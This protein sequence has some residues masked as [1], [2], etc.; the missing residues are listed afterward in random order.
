IG[1]VSPLKYQT[2]HHTHSSPGSTAR[3]LRPVAEPF[4]GGTACAFMRWIRGPSSRNRAGRRSCHSVGGST[5]WS[6]T[7][8]IRS[9][10]VVDMRPN[11]ERR[12]VRI[13]SILDMSIPAHGR[14]LV[15]REYGAPL[16]VREYPVRAPEP[17]A[18]LVAVE[19]ATI[20]GSDVHLWQGSYS[21]Y[22]VRLPV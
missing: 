7:E 1:F 11:L 3:M 20:C 5:R 9:A 10:A 13:N 12:I 17:G 15:I 4:V 21:H 2:S 6:S 8:T 22:G 16:E 14:G 19:A 18:I